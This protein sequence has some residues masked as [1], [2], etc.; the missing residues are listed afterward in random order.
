M[1][2]ENQYRQQVFHRDLRKNLAI[3]G[4]SVLSILAYVGLLLLLP[5][6][7]RRP[8]LVLIP[9]LAFTLLPLIFICA[10]YLIRVKTWALSEG[11]VAEVF[12]EYD[13]DYPILF[14]KILF[15]DRSGTTQTLNIVLESFGDEE[16]QQEED[17][18]VLQ[19]VIRENALK[20]EGASVPV[21]YPPRKPKKAFVILEDRKRKEETSENHNLGKCHP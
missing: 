21:F 2:N 19:E 13:S 17:Y 6:N 15:P 20:Y 9:F 14:A 16:E 10:R 7:V 4:V 12:L 11:Y 3:I 1:E 5:G 18:P 8:F